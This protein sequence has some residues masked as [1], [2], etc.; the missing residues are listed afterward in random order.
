MVANALHRHI[1]LPRTLLIRPYL[2][3]R[4]HNSF[5]G[6]LLGILHQHVLQLIF[7]APRDHLLLIQVRLHGF[8]ILERLFIWRLIRPL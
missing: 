5:V 1:F 8:L 2:R 3:I 4:L 6:L 7:L